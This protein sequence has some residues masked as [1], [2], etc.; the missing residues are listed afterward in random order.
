[1]SDEDSEGVEM[2][3]DGGE[4]EGVLNFV[5]GLVWNHANIEEILGESRLVGCVRI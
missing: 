2:I 3:V 1:M 5:D 4:K